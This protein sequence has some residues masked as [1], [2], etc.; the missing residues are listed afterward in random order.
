MDYFLF[1]L[2]TFFKK[3]LNSQLL[4]VYCL[5][6]SAMQGM[7]QLYN[8]SNFLFFVGFYQSEVESLEVPR[9]LNFCCWEA[10]I[11]FLNSKKYVFFKFEWLSG[12]FCGLN[13]SS[14]HPLSE[15]DGWPATRATRSHEDPEDFRI[16]HKNRA[17]SEV[18]V[19][20]YQL[21]LPE[22]RFL[23]SIHSMFIKLL[24]LTNFI[25]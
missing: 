2:F 20:K 5:K 25:M 19:S 7:A 12:N 18:R 14:S 1:D 9:P 6:L 24:P 3:G 22:N 10:K 15:I 23:L 17:F 8:L 13:Y 16:S 4:R 21:N 11:S